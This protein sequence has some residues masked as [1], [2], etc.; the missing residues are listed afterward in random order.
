MKGLSKFFS[1]ALFVFSLLAACAPARAQYT[2]YNA[3]V[4]RTTT[5]ALAVNDLLSYVIVI[6]NQGGTL[7][8]NIFLTNAFSAPVQFL[9]ATNSNGGSNTTNGNTL[10]FFTPQI[11][12]FG[13]TA[14]IGVTIRPLTAGLL[15]NRLDI[16]GP[17][18]FPSSVSVFNEVTNVP[19]LEADV[20]V[21]ITTPPGPFYPN[22]SITYSLIV[23]NLG[24]NAANV[25][26]T[27]GLKGLTFLNA[28]PKQT[29]RSG[30]N[31][32]FNLG[33]LSNLAFKVFNVTVQATNAAGTNAVSAFA[34][35]T[36]NTD[37]NTT[38][39]VASADIVVAEFL[40]NQLVAFTNDGTQVFNPQ[41]G[42]MEQG[43]L[44]SNASPTAVPSARVVVAGLR[45]SDRLFNAVGTNGGQPFVEFPTTLEANE[46]V[47]MLL[48][49]YVPSHAPFP[50]P[51]SNLT[52]QALS[53]PVDLTPPPNLIPVTNTP[54]GF[55]RITNLTSKIL[56]EFPS[57]GGASYAIV[58]SDDMTFTTS[59]VARPFIVAPANWTYWY[60]YGP[61]TTISA[62][63][64]SASR[65]YKVFQVPN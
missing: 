39:N 53:A 16:T 32:V 11:I 29:S 26:L 36:G 52:A 59:R 12:G 19:G 45:S 10:T 30:T 40:T 6:T 51:N 28:S 9:E 7:M 2:N 25:V 63:T 1:L 23:T 43:I 31:V 62:P 61:P 3:K 20:A 65:F 56:I 55:T 44:L 14:S 35:L 4:F 37:P 5:N 17:G 50:L 54:N 48:Q 47:A 13:G 58:Y 18:V 46:T 49:F 27:N 42:L 15:T 33:S 22:D 57:T 24:P 60:D 34:A 41:V 21:E 8:Q 38:N 64:N